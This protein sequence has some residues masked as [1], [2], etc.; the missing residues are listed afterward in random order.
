MADLVGSD[1]DDE[2]PELMEEEIQPALEF[3]NQT[4]ITLRIKV[5]SFPIVVAPLQW[6]FVELELA[7]SHAEWETP[8]AQLNKLWVV[9]PVRELG[10]SS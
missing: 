7:P 9:S 5:S 10:V 6:A 1:S 4:I 8:L 3:G 2:A